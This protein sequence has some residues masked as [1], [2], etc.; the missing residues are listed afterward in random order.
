MEWFYNLSNTARTIIIVT[1]L[2]LIAVLLWFG[3]NS[4]P[5][6]TEDPPDATV[7]IQTPGIITPTPTPDE[8]EDGEDEEEPDTEPEPID[9]MERIE[10]GTDLSADE[11]A[12]ALSVAEVGLTEWLHVD[13]RESWEEREARV[14]PYVSLDSPMWNDPPIDRSELESDNDDSTLYTLVTIGS[15]EPIGG[16]KD[17]FRVLIVATIQM[18]MTMGSGEDLFAQQFSEN[19]YFHVA[20]KK[21]DDSWKL[22]NYD[23]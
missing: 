13:S 19:H 6:N 17:D 20:L 10:E 23:N 7:P 5:E 21:S 1:G 2:A 3:I 18:E 4:A 8:T 12:A 16:T 14:S 9:T 22:Y 15:V 11:V